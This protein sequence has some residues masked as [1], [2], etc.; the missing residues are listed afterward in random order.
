MHQ[1]VMEDDDFIQ[2]SSARSHN[3]A[4]NIRTS[5]NQKSCCCCYYCCC[6]LL[7]TAAASRFGNKLWRAII[8]EVS[9]Q[10]ILNLFGVKDMGLADLKESLQQRHQHCGGRN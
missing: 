6:V 5:D 3:L 1:E 4:T 2:V 9:K 7:R 8:S 10:L